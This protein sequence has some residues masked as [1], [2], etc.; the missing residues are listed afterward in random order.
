MVHMSPALKKRSPVKRSSGVF[1][2]GGITI[3]SGLLTALAPPPVDLSAQYQDLVAAATDAAAP[4]PEPPPPPPPPPPLP[5]DPQY[6]ANV[7]AA[8]LGYNT[9]REQ[10]QAARG[11]LGAQYG[12]GVGADG[13][14]FDDHSN[15]FS[16]A[17]ALQTAHDQRQSGNTN[18][19]AARGQLYSGALLNAQNANER[20][21]LQGRD[22]LIRQFMDARTNLDNRDTAANNALLNAKGAADAAALAR[23]LGL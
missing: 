7:N 19:Y 13:N 10:T 17:A 2:G 9:T 23:A 14:V 11:Q 22:V 6:K 16:R 3:G 1:T 8:Q 21:N 5:V 12:F 15:P 20:Q 18:S 4:P